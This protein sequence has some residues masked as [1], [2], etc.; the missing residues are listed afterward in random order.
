[1]IYS[2]ESFRKYESSKITYTMT[3]RFHKVWPFNENLKLWLDLLICPSAF[4]LVLGSQRSK[5]IHLFYDFPA[6]MINEENS[7]FF[8]YL[9]KMIQTYPHDNGVCQ[10]AKNSRYLRVYFSFFNKQRKFLYYLSLS[11]AVLISF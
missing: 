4:H 2:I 10:N 1:M 8:L 3:F 9:H 5:L 7:I 11:N 6:H